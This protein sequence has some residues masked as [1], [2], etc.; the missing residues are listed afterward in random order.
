MHQ[1]H[2]PFVT[3]LFFQTRFSLNRQVEQLEPSVKK[4]R[5]LFHTNSKSFAKNPTL[6]LNAS[7]QLFRCCKHHSRICG[8][9]HQAK[10]EALLSPSARQSPSRFR[11]HLL[12]APR[13]T[14]PAC[15][16]A[17][18]APAAAASALRRVKREQARARESRRASDRLSHTDTRREHQ[19]TAD[20]N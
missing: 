20:P 4:L 7:E 3:A 19:T 1:Y 12:Q 5:F 16:V 13:A 2:H 18:W 8:V 10:S 14:S 17:S 11:C 15:S 9:E 6:F